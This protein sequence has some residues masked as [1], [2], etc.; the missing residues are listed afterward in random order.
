MQ[1]S[2]W[3]NLK[4]AYGIL[5]C[6]DGLKWLSNHMGYAED[7]IL[8]T[9]LQQKEITF[10]NSDGAAATAFIKSKGVDWNTVKLRN[11]TFVVPFNHNII[12]DKKKNTFV[13]SSGR[14]IEMEVAIGDIKRSDKII[15]FPE[16]L[17]KLKILDNH[18]SDNVKLPSSLIRLE[19][20]DKFDQS[21][22]ELN[23]RELTSLTHLQI[24]DEGDYKIYRSNYSQ[25]IKCLRKL[26]NK[27]EF[28][29]FHVIANDTIRKW[30]D[31]NLMKPQTKVALHPISEPYMQ[32]KWDM[33]KFTK[34]TVDLW[35]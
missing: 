11:D 10:R 25:C 18:P 13:F 12:V 33:S 15:Q 28:F 14:L 7:E 30:I 20:S 32:C 19:F 16:G 5:G 27:L 22:D 17:M 31:T 35:N 21:L 6:S 29:K 26:P 1:Q 8:N 23:L 9:G 3:I 34:Y 24:G 4:L 2:L